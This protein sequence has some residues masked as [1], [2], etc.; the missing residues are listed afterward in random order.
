MSTFYTKK[1]IKAIKIYITTIAIEIKY[2]GTENH[3][4][5]TNECER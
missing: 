1:E 2:I 5:N 3:H 4:K